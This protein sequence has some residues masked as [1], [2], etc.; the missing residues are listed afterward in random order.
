MKLGHRPYSVARHLLGRGERGVA[1]Q[2]H[3]AGVFWPP[4]STVAD[5]ALRVGTE[6][7]GLV[8]GDNGDRVTGVTAKGADGKTESFAGHK[9]LLA[10][11]GFGAGHDIFKEIYRLPALHL[12]VAGVAP[13]K[14]RAW[15]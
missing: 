5:V 11:G 9:V 12:G 7:T 8:Q 3:R 15:R 10:T 1:A 6:V 4:S 13:A 14:A 2:G